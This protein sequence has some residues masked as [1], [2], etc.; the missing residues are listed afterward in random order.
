M[1]TVE[2]HRP[3]TIDQTEQL[4]E[5]FIR[6]FG[7]VPTPAQLALFRRARSALELRLPAQVR[8]AAA[9]MVANL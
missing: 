8:R 4:T 5:R 3:E 1:S 9:S 6:E 2:N 7:R